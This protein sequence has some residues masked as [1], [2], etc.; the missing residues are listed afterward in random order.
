[1]KK[2]SI[3]SNEQQR[4]EAI[5]SLGLLAEEF[6]RTHIDKIVATVKSVFDVGLAMFSIIERDNQHAL[7]TA[8]K[9]LD[10]IPR[11]LSFC[12]HVIGDERFLCVSDARLDERFADNPIVCGDPHLRFYAGLPVR[13]REGVNIGVLCI[14]DFA[15]REF[16]SVD[17]EILRGF[18]D[19]LETILHGPQEVLL[20]SERRLF[21]DQVADLVTRIQSDFM[22]SETDADAFDLA[23]NGILSI[24][25]SE[26]GFIGQILKDEAQKPFL[27]TYSITDISWNNSTRDF[28]RDNIAE[29]LEFHNVQTLFGHTITTGEPLITND[30]QNH[31][32][33]GGLPQGHPRLDT[34]LG[35]PILYGEK[36]VGM[37]GIANRDQ[38][39]SERILKQLAPITT[40]ISH[41]IVASRMR[42]R[43]HK[44]SLELSKLSRVVRQAN[45]SVLMT[46]KDGAIEWVNDAFLRMSGYRKD[47]LSGRKPGDLLQGALS[48]P[49]VVAQMAGA[50]R[51]GRGFDVELVNYRKDKSPYWVQI[52]CTPTYSEEG[53]HTGYLSI[54]TDIS[55]RK[56][57][58]HEKAELLNLVTGVSDQVPGMMYQLKRTPDAQLLVPFASKG[59][60]LV[61]DVSP[62]ELT[63]DAAGLFS[64]I[65]PEDLPVLI[66]EI[67][68]SANKMS[69][70]VHEHRVR[71]QNGSV[72]WVNTEAT[73]SRDPLG[74]IVWHGYAHDT[75]DRKAEHEAVLLA[76]SVFDH[77]HDGIMLAS[78]S[79]EILDVNR[80]FCRIT[81]FSKEEVLS[82]DL[83]LLKTTDHGD[84][85]FR[86][87]SNSLSEN[88]SWEGEVWS[89]RKNGS[90]FLGHQVVT[91]V[92]GHDGELLHYLYQ[93]SD[94][95]K[96]RD[97]EN[98]L[99]R[100]AHYDPLTGLANRTLLLKNMHRAME[101]CLKSGNMLAVAY[102]D[103]DG[104]KQLNDSLGHEHGDEFLTSVGAAL[105]KVIKSRDTLA[106]I[107]GDEFVALLCDVPDRPSLNKVLDRL[108]RA[109]AKCSER[110]KDGVDVSLSVGV[111]TYPENLEKIDEITPDT[112]IRQADQAMYKAKLDGK[113]RYH[114][115]DVRENYITEERAKLIEDVRKGLQRKEFE[116]YYQ[117]KV[118]FL[119][120]AVVGLEALIRWNHPTR[121][122]MLPGQFLGVIDGADIC[123]DLGCFVVEEAL[124]QIS[125]HK[126]CF[127]LEMPISINVSATELQH[128]EFF[129]RLRAAV[130]SCQFFRDGLLEIEI[131]ESSAIDD[132]VRVANLIEECREIGVRSSIDDFGTGYAALQYLQKLPAHA[133]K[134]D[135]SFVRGIA[136]GKGNHAILRALKGL[137][138]AFRFE[139]IAEGVETDQHVHT[140][141][142]LGYEVGQGFGV[143]RPMPADK[144][145]GWI[146]KWEKPANWVFSDAVS[147]PTDFDIRCLSCSHAG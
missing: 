137:A 22:V 2:P 66:E 31:P 80:A 130:S 95:T 110:S 58:E 43:H 129:K 27:K 113:S 23:L 94:I 15:P 128:P 7:S 9:E 48:S 37:F 103:L 5:N 143:A 53:E 64:V 117:P 144:V 24:T 84:I 109:G 62:D 14:I 39:Y 96:Q 52:N 139:T 147:S 99:K 140:L 102:I 89:K 46:S 119:T 38:G 126:K 87:M 97:Y 8:G 111:V 65:H 47:E 11:D 121:G 78:P 28:Y 30:P 88:G 74:N 40:T 135:Q 33:S 56:A 118:N 105:K 108:L 67:E 41:L 127:Q 42:E 21:K 72:R 44:A 93:I 100:M 146:S 13:N 35:V 76:A 125:L 25:E 131:L 112:L 45:T 70:M 18:R 61:Y 16:G 12:G 3:P 81:G 134:V 19:I 120:G 104:F 101:E 55:D 115:F 34:Y 114:F 124:R 57:A 145:I 10:V 71:F 92:L 68:H 20:N 86:E 4:L 1:M 122:F 49:N 50:L 6:D 69:R 59:S 106:R 77:S 75:T 32:K 98:K 54:Q 36:L 91:E 83:S 142:A 90:K 133:I 73:P 116:L 51:E 136:D 132:L 82:K 107:G 79:G 17:Y 85:F 63:K 26:Y 60:K 123:F 29:G 138:E 141:V